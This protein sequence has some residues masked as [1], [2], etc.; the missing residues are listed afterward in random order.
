MAFTKSTPIPVQK[1]KLKEM[2]RRLSALQQDTLLQLP[3]LLGFPS[4]PAF[5]RAASNAYKSG[6]KKRTQSVKPQGAK[7]K[8]KLAA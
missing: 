8:L 4:F 7:P 6:S 3:D 1:A 5:L 2:Q